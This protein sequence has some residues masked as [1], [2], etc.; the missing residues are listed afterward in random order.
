MQH[1]RSLARQASQQSS[2]HEAA[3]LAA[4]QDAQYLQQ[5]VLGLRQQL[6]QADDSAQLQNQLTEVHLH[7]LFD[8]LASRRSIMD[9]RTLGSNCLHLPGVSLQCE[10]LYLHGPP[11]RPTSAH[12]RCGLQI[13]INKSLIMNGRR[14][15]LNGACPFSPTQAGCAPSQ[16]AL[17]LLLLWDFSP[18]SHHNSISRAPCKGSISVQTCPLV[19]K[20]GHCIIE[21]QCYPRF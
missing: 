14:H 13:G 8:S 9:H 19:G 6:A 11:R 21:V 10:V 1:Q 2:Q 3:A 5:E 18:G 12:A 15:S 4:Q 16:A 7:L 20:I 17:P